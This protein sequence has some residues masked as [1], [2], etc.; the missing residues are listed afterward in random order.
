M[1]TLS[2]L[3]P[4][5][6]QFDSSSGVPLAGGLLYSY[7]A[8]TTTPQATYTDS[9]GTTAQTNPVV[10]GVDGGASVWLGALGYK[11]VLTDAFGVQQWSQDNCSSV[12]LAQLTGTNSFTSLAVTGGFTAGSITSTGL[13]GAVTATISGAASVG[14]ALTVS[15]NETVSGNASIGGA[16]NVNGISSLAATTVT[17]GATIDALSIGNAGSSV[18]LAATIAAAIAAGA[19]SSVAGTLIITNIS[20]SGGWVLITFGATSGTRIQFAFGSGTVANGAAIALPSGYSVANFYGTVSLNSVS[21]TSGNQLG[22]INCSLSGLTV[23]V[24]GSD[25]SGHV[26]SGTANWSGFAYITG[27]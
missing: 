17:G 22:N 7:A 13:F 4:P 16:L 26:Y 11:F 23:A 24:Q 12:S 15:G 10:L 9:T 14:G 19:V 25:N 18:T 6:I 8:G 5:R 21:A 27:F 20:T 3:V 1:S 2:L